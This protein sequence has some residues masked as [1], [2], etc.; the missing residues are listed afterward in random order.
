[1][2]A[3]RGANN[4][5]VTLHNCSRGRRIVWPIERGAWSRRAPARPGATDS[6]LERLELVRMFVAEDPWSIEAEPRHGAREKRGE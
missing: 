5:T 4:I 3:I 1:M 2:T 6:R